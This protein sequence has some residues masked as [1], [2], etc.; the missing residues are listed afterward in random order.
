LHFNPL[1]NII[2]SNIELERV[3]MIRSVLSRC[4]VPLWEYFVVSGDCKG[5]V[6]DIAGAKGWE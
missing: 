5:Q 6:K 3:S 2:P 1:K 4:S